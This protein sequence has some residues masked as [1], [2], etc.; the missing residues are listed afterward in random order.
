METAKKV[1]ILEGF[2]I[3]PGDTGST[4]VQV[5]LL[6]QRVTEITDHLRVHR[7]DEHTRR[8]L[9]KLVGQ[10]RRLLQYLKDEDVERYRSLIARL[11]L[12]R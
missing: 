3:H 8:G 5:A 1:E 12:R 4:E 10:R 2:A 7:H 11:G 9:F 6:T